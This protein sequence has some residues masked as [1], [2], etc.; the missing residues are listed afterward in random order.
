[1]LFLAQADNAQ[2]ALQLQAFDI[3]EEVFRVV[4]FLEI[5]AEERDV[6]LV[7]EGHAELVADPSLVQRAVTNLV[8]NAI[9]HCFIGTCVRIKLSDSGEG[10]TLEVIN[11]GKPIAPEYLPRLFERFF[12][13]DDARARDVGGSGL[14]LSIVKAIM[15]MHDGQVSV[16]SSTE[17]ETRFTLFFPGRNRRV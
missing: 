2:S 7:I 15:Q 5:L 1:M 9:R 17:G 6:K 16:S 12:R 3:Y 4:D 8:S 13:V 14:G 10:V 11:Q